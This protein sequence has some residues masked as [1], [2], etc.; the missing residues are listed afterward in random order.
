[1]T[2]NHRSRK[3]IWLV[4]IMVGIL[5]WT[6]CGDSDT[7]SEQA[8]PSATPFPTPPKDVVLTMGSWRPDDVEQM[9]NILAAGRSDPNIQR[10]MDFQAMYFNSVYSWNIRIQEWI[11]LINSI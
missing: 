8:A 7:S 4:L 5:I 2:W 11:D 6:G 3:V 9:N 10:R 1:M